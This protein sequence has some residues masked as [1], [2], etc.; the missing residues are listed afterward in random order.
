MLPEEWA[1]TEKLGRNGR[2]STDD[3]LALIATV[4]PEITP[5]AIAKI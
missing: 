1:D 5:T 2:T 3:N 4:S